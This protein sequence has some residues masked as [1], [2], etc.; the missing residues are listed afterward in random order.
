MQELAFAPILRFAAFARQPDAALRLDEGALMIAEIARP[1]LDRTHYIHELD[2]LAAEVWAALGSSARLLRADQAMRRATAQRVL[3]VMVEVLSRRERFHGADESYSDPRNSFLDAV[4]DRREGL[5]ITLSI[6]YLEVARRLGAPLQGVGLPAHFMVKWPLSP[7]EGGDLYVDV[8]DHGELLD[9]ATCR[10]F[11]LRLLSP[12]TAR[13]FDPTWS[14][15]LSVRQI[16]TRV[17]Y[18]L[19]LVY[20]HRGETSSAL[21]VIDRLVLLRPDLPQELRDRGLLRL[22][23]GESLLAAAD[24]AAYLERAPDAPENARLRRRIQ[25]TREVRAKLN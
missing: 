15:A 5:P 19:K 6:V 2:A 25:A 9:E 21:D 8:F 18:N 23:M 13:T 4:L 16:L 22:A 12:Q 1:Q 11:I 14:R 7:D 3:E 24:I 20:L 10:Q 17:L